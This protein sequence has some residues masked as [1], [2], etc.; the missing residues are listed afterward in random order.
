MRHD[1]HQERIEGTARYLERRL[2]FFYAS[3][4]S[5]ALLTDP[6]ERLGDDRYSDGWVRWFYAQLRHYETG[7]AIIRL[8]DQFEVKDVVN[9]IEAG[10]SPA[11]VLADHLG[12]G[13]EMA[14]GLLAEA[15]AAYDP[16]EQ[17]PAVAARL[18][19]AAA[20]EDWDGPGG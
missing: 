2:G 15:R 4:G 9:R 7:A 13:Q 3:D 1:E 18:A 17:L 8:L 14:E 11:Q 20:R 10:L 19:A 12:V 5:S 16:G 6:E